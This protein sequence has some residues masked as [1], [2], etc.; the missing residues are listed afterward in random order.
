MLQYEMRA[1]SYVF[2]ITARGARKGDSSAPRFLLEDFTTTHW[3][4][5]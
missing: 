1:E 5:A 4:K 2:A 3:Q